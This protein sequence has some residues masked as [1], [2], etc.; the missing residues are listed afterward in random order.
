MELTHALYVGGSLLVLLAVILLGSYLAGRFNPS[1]EI[2]LPVG[3]TYCPLCQLTL[4]PQ[5]RASHDRVCAGLLRVHKSKGRRVTILVFR[6][7]GDIRVLKCVGPF[8]CY[9]MD[10]SEVSH[11]NGPDALR[12]ALEQ[13]RA[14]MGEVT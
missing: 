3:P 2:P 8:A 1:Q 5:D 9:G 12:R 4:R 14:E 7:G 6:E 13:V 11:G 10:I